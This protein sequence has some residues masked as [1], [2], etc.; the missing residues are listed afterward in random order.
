MKLKTDV[1]GFQSHSPPK[2]FHTVTVSESY[3]VT[4][5]VL[6]P[7]F[8]MTH[9]QPLFYFSRTSSSVLFLQRFFFY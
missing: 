3:N 5:I 8:F 4:L 9:V 2:M 6:Y 7:H 1:T